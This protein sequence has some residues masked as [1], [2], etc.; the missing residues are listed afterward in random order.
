M[1]ERDFTELSTH[2]RTSLRHKYQSSQAEEEQAPRSHL[3]KNQ[4]ASVMVAISLG[5]LYSLLPSQAADPCQPD[6]KP[7]DSDY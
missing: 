7:A 2:H 5:L 4:W 1:Y 6:S 3:A